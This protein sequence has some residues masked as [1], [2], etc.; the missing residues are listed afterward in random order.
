MRLSPLLAVV[1]PLLGC[2]AATGS[3]RA[4]QPSAMPAERTARHE[5][6]DDLGRRL[7]AALVAGRP[8]DILLGDDEL[9]RVLTSD[10]ATRFAARRAAVGVRL[11]EGG[12]FA[13]AL[14]E[15]S[16]LGVCLQDAR[17]RDD[18]LGLRSPGWTVRRILLAA[19]R[20]GG[21][22]IALWVEGVFVYTDNGFGAID[23]ERVED[24]RWEHSDLELAP[25]DMATSL[26]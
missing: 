21:R 4:T 18:H 25:C 12:R 24:P 6:M 1:V 3:R 5:A 9:R 26:R 15:T 23:I 8:A 22:R 7:H 16:Y 20:P 10:V 2:G 17:D 11:G 19:R 14:A 13:S